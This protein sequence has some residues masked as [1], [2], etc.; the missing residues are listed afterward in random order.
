MPPRVHP[1]ASLRVQAITEIIRPVIFEFASQLISLPV[2]NHIIVAVRE[3]GLGREGLPCSPLAPTSELAGR[4]CQLPLGLRQIR[5]SL[6]ARIP[7]AA[8]K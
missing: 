1:V 5:L 2:S 8:G 4:F 7:F 6:A 3:R